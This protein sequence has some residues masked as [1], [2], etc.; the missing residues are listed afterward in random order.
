[1]FVRARNRMAIAKNTSLLYYATYYGL[2]KF[3]DYRASTIKL[4]TDVI[5]VI[6]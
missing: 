1:M 5:F 2:K 4:F 6:S 3:Y